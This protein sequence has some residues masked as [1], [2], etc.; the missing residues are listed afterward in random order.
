MKNT[1]SRI[2]ALSLIALLAGSV[3]S[4]AS[5]PVEDE[6]A[7]TSPRAS[8]DVT[9]ILPAV[10]QE[11][12]DF[13]GE[14]N[15]LASLNANVAAPPIALKDVPPEVLDLVLDGIQPPVKWA[16]NGKPYLQYRGEIII[17]EFGNVCKEWNAIAR[18]RLE[19]SHHFMESWQLTK[20]NIKS[21]NHLQ[22]LVIVFS[23]E[24][25]VCGNRK[26]MEII[27][28]LTNV[29]NL[30]LN[31]SFPMKS[32]PTKVVFENPNRFN[33]L[34]RLV[35]SGVVSAKHTCYF[36]RLNNLQINGQISSEAFNFLTAIHSLQMTDTKITGKDRQYLRGLTNLSTLDIFDIKRPKVNIGEELA[37][38]TN[39]TDLS[40]DVCRDE[41]DFEKKLGKLTNLKNLSLCWQHR[42]INQETLMEGLTGLTNLVELRARELSEENK[43]FIKAFLT[44]LQNL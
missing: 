34:N 2:L 32:K 5:R 19:K 24:N 42:L 15:A 43:I 18:K 10:T 30:Q 14:T 21:L 29:Q 27:G 8:A 20:H 40:T 16:S 44:N 13:L 4:F 23:P 35:L 37:C 11:W 9:P 36:T 38:L 25:R 6:A 39:L 28:N 31:L 7:G 41:I 22:S 33:H 17:K 12:N 3:D 1:K 26:M